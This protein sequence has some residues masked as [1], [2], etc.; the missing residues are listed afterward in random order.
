MIDK[1]LVVYNTCGITPRENSQSYK[2]SLESLLYQDGD[3]CDVVMSSCLNSGQTRDKVQNYF[4]N[5]LMYNFVNEPHPVNVTFNHAIDN[6]VKHNDEYAGYMY[7]DSGSCLYPHRNIMKS[8]YEYLKEGRYGMITPQPSSDTEYHEGLGFGQFRGDDEAA[9]E[10][11]FKDGDYIIPVGKAC[12]PHINVISNDLRSF[13]GRVYPD[14]FAS[15][16]TESTFSFINAAL[17]KQWILLKDF[18]VNHQISMDGQSSGFNPSV[19]INETGRPTFDHPY[20]IPSII[21]RLCT[22]EAESCGFGYEECRNV[23]LHHDYH[24]DENYHCT[25]DKLKH[26]IK[27]NLFL[28]KEELDYEKIEHEYINKGTGTKKKATKKKATKKKATSKKSTRKKSISSKRGL[29]IYNICG[30]KRDNTEA[31]ITY[32]TNLQQQVENFDGELKVIVS[33]CKPHERTIPHLISN[34]PEFDYLDISEVLPVNITFNCAVLD[35]IKKYGRFD[36]YTYIA[37]DAALERPDGLDKMTSAIKADKSI[38]MLSAQIDIDSCYAYGLKL[39]GGKH[40]IDDERARNEMF[41]DATDYIVPVGRACGAHLN[42]YSRGFVDF[43]GR[44]LPDIFAGYCTE[45]VF[46]FLNA[47]IKKNWVISRDFSIKH[48]AGLDGP[49]CGFDAE[50]H[51]QSSPQGGYD[52][53]FIGDSLLPIFTNET[54]KSLGLGYEECQEVV[55][56]DNSQFDEDQFCINNSL[57]QYIKDN[58]YL[59]QEQFDYDDIKR[60]YIVS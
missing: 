20:L 19:W 35:G 17:S 29:A 39:G 55:M 27:E 38:G 26:F 18:I 28:S 51:R 46:S 5:K 40:G 4:G 41:K 7:M 54:A 15:H 8:L 60:E 24:F 42:M 45:S 31:Y 37:A 9:R 48:N 21:E 36:S 50:E 33:A 10:L 52:H 13:Y 6:V 44:C 22:E 34:M 2:M 59:S 3:Y 47:A 49:S 32:L 43:Y 53:P 57:K 23:F 30:I 16:C 14:I 58:L 25:N 56:H 11:I 1:I 12:A